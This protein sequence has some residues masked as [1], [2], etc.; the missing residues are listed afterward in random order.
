MNKI[1]EVLKDKKILI[2]GYGREGRSTHRYLIKH[3]LTEHIT[4]CDQKKI[5][6]EEM[7]GEA[8]YFPES[9]ITSH[10]DGFDLIIKSPGISLKETQL[11]RK[12][13]SQTGIFLAAYRE[14]VIG[15]TGTKGK[16]TTSTLIYEMFKK[17]GREVVLVGNIGKPVFDFLDE[18]G[19]ETKIVYEMSSHQLEQLEMSPKVAIFLNIYE[20]HLDYYASFDHYIQ[21]KLNIVRFQN[22][23]DVAILPEAVLRMSREQRVEIKARQILTDDPNEMFH[24]KQDQI[25]YKGEQVFDHQ[26]GKNLLGQHNLSNML[27]CFIVGHLHSIDFE[28]IQETITGFTGLKHRMEYIDTIGE[29]LFYDDSIST[30]PETCM[31]SIESLKKVSSVILGGLDRGV[32]YQTLIDYLKQKKELNV[33]CISSTGRKVYDALKAEKQNIYFFESLEEAVAKA[34]EVTEKGHICLL[35]PAAASYNDFKN[36]EERGDQFKSYIKEK[37]KCFT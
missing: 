23:G 20:E 6:I 34:F 4:I 17:A 11:E 22:E 32:N 35:S 28:T 15:I 21:A 10:S 24:V 33:L 2:Y 14:R 18:I 36:F 37:G 9:E 29:I 13:D 31:L 12:V 5:E 1:E 8:A 25:F 19:P 30:I 16:S 3:A 27:I 26:D 7:E